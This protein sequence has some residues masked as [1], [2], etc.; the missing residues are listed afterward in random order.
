MTETLLDLAA[1]PGELTSASSPYTCPEC[2]S[3]LD[4]PRVHPASGELGRKCAP[5]QDWYRVAR[6]SGAGA[7][8]VD[9]S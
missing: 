3:F 5:C 1:A 8:S 9:Q 6:V 7:T 2:G 4:A